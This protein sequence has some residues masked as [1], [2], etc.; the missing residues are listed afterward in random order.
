MFKKKDSQLDKLEHESKQLDKKVKEKIER[1]P[2]PV[3]YEGNR[4]QSVIL[5]II[6]VAASLFFYVTGN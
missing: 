6:T 1:K 2:K 4:W 3:V 5:L